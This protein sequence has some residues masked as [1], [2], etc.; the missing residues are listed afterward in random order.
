MVA[1]VAAQARG[2]RN[3]DNVRAHLRLGVVQLCDKFAGEGRASDV[4]ADPIKL[5]RL[6]IP[7]RRELAELHQT[8]R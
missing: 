2:L 3:R 5:G 7:I 4:R 1:G 8:L 6:R